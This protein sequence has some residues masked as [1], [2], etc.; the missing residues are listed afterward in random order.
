MAEID[1]VEASVLG[2]EN[3]EAV[4]AG[5]DGGRPDAA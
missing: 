5:V 1:P 2:N 3:L 4:G